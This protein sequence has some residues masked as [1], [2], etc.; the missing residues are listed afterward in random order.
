MHFTVRLASASDVTYLPEIERSAAQQFIPYLDWLAIPASLLEGLTTPSFLLKA[1]ADNRLWVGVVAEQPVGFIVAKYLLESCFIVELDVHPE[2]GHRGI[3][4]AL[5]EACCQGAQAQG[6]EW[7]TLT[8]FRKVPWN[9]PF[10]RRL[11]FEVL[12]PTAWSAEISAIVRHEARY[13]FAP[14]KRAVMCRSISA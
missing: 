8:T 13:G 1:Q 6:F 11:G 10:Y 14:E 9:I 2:F 3:G 12:P 5:V 4:S 7:V